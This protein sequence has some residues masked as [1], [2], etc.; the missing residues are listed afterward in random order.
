MKP[1]AM[2]LRPTGCATRTFR[3]R[4]RQGDQG[5]RKNA[6]CAPT[7]RHGPLNEKMMATIYQQH[8]YQHPVIGW[9][10]D[11]ES[12]TVGDACMVSPLVHP[13]NATLVI[14][15]DVKADEAFALA[16]T[17]MARSPARPAAAAC[18]SPNSRH[19]AHGGESPA[20]LPHLVMSH[21]AHAAISRTGLKPYALQILAGVLTATNRRLN[22][23]RART[24][25]RQRAGAGYDAT[26]R[27]LSLFTSP[28]PAK[29]DEVTPRWREIALPA[30]ASGEEQR[31]GAG[32]GRGKA[33]PLFYRA[34]QI[35]QM[36]HRADPPRDSGDAGK[37]QQ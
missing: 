30:T 11:L 7:T 19:Q 1:L 29:T 4:F 21:H 36:E 27:G 28:R 24:A 3:R 26:S 17:T 32:G 31:Q 16:C 22:K 2:A 10:S 9:M 33:R 6:A 15:G 14:A 23:H 12:L 5:G 13:N 37:L 18:L 20:E 35:G 8:P 34:M 25:G